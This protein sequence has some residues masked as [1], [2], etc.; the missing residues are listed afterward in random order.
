VPDRDRHQVHRR[1]GERDAHEHREGPVPR[2]EREGHQLGLVAQLGDEH[3]PEAD[4][5]GKQE[6]VHVAIDATS[7]RGRG[8]TAKFD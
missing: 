4:G 1:R 7:V 6:S 3:H 5:E 2:G 8:W